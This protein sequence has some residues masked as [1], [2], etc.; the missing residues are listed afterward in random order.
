MKQS[1]DDI[2][3]INPIPLPFDINDKIFRNCDEECE[4]NCNVHPLT[5]MQDFYDELKNI[6]GVNQ[7]LLGELK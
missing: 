6:S 2:R 7:E 1:T 5:S 3:K 4:D